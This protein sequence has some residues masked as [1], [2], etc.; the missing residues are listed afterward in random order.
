MV[1]NVH[2]LEMIGEKEKTVNSF[3][4]HHHGICMEE[5]RQFM[6]S[7]GQDNQWVGENPNEELLK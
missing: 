5:L 1:Y 6:K 2:K 4:L 7:L 3:E